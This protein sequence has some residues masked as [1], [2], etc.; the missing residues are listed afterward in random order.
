MGRMRGLADQI[1][2]IQGR[3]VYHNGSQWIDSGI[4]GLRRQAAQRIRF[5]SPEYYQLLNRHP[6]SAQF[7]ALGRNVKFVVNDQIVEIHD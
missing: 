6:S 7:L 5:G 3:A 1:K 4:H 2:T